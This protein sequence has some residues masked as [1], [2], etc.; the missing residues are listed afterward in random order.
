MS[1][2]MLVIT[3]RLS[4]PEQE[5]QFQASRSSGPGGQNV[6]KVNTR[7]MLHFDVTN[8]PSLTPTQKSLIGRKLKTRVT[9]EGMLYLYAQRA[10]SQAMNRAEL[11]E[12]FC[13]LLCEAL[14]PQK[15]R[16]KT[17]RSQHSI[18]KRLDQKTRRGR[19][20]QLR[21]RPVTIDD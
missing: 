6:N 11:L 17:R 20:K 9:K 4:I 16:K 15:I 3:S 12:K 2:R 18:E 8:S 21:I 14:T 10:S 5:L 1:K 19:V 7:V 13:R